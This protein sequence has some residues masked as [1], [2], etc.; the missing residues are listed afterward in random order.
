MN[1][2]R[3]NSSCSEF[4]VVEYLLLTFG[5]HGG[6][7]NRRLLL[8]V[9]GGVKK[10]RK[11]PNIALIPV[12]SIYNTRVLPTRKL[13]RVRAMEGAGRTVMVRDSTVQQPILLK[14]SFFF[15]P[16]FVKSAQ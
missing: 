16:I 12:S 6:W 5:L 8:K 7:R 14:V 10:M 9:G 11:Y 1:E 15:F 2:Q 3:V 13:N 4:E